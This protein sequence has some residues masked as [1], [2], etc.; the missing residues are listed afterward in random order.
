MEAVLN[1][2]VALLD[3]AGVPAL[4]FRALA[5]RLGG[6]VG[7]IYWYVASKDELLDRAADHV[8]AG[9]LADTEDVGEGDDPIADLRTIAVRMFD[10]IAVRPW[11][12]AYFMRDSGIQPHMMRLYERLG[13]QILRLDL[14][15]RQRFDAVSAVIGY[16]VGT[17]ADMGQE[18][19]REVA[20]GELTREEYLGHWAD[21]WRALDPEAYPFVHH[22][23]EEFAHHDDTA[24]FRAGLDLLLAGLRLQAEG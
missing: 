17:A 9:V 15:T 19:P 21:Q 14:T 23:V 13:Q 4:T 18:P 6:G 5:A 7:S 1:E 10:A 2:A 8:L 11:L 12:G 16:V 3:E 22:I 24:Q 20:E